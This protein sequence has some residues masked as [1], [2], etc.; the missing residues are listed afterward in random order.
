MKDSGER[1]GASLNAQGVTW[2]L[3][4]TIIRS[5]RG[6]RSFKGEPVWKA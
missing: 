3:A 5:M 6:E 1:R 2:I 4:A